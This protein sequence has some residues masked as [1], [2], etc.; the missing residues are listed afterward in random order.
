MPVSSQGRPDTQYENLTDT[1]G[2]RKWY[3]TTPE[4]L[5]A[6][7]PDAMATS[8]PGIMH[9]RIAARANRKPQEFAFDPTAKGEF[10]PKK[11]M[12]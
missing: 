10:G 4:E 6:A 9:V 1:F 3:V 7:L 11:S 2:G 5:E 12:L 8:Q